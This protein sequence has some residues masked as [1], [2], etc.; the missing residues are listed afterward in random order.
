MSSNPTHHSEKANTFTA[1]NI[2]RSTGIQIGH[3]NTQET[4]HHYYGDK[5]AEK[6]IHNR[7][8]IGTNHS[9]SWSEAIHEFPLWPD[10]GLTNDFKEATIQLANACWEQHQRACQAMPN[11]VWVDSE[12]PIRLL[13]GLYQLTEKMD[14]LALNVAEVALLCI[15]P[16][17][18]EAILARAIEKMAVH[19]PLSLHDTGCSDGMR[20][21]LEKVHRSY[22]RLLRKA[23]RLH[24]SGN[25]EAAN[26]VALWLMHR[27]LLREPSIWFSSND[28]EY[29]LFD[30][31]V[32]DALHAIKQAKPLIK[33]T[34][35]LERLAKLARYCYAA[36]ERPSSLSA[37]DFVKIGWDTKPIHE[38][39]LGYLLIIAGAMA[40]DPRVL[41]SVLVEHIGVLHTP[42]L[43]K[44]ID[45][46]I[47][48]QWDPEQPSGFRLRA[49]CTH[50]APDY[51]LGEHV[52]NTN[53]ILTAAR[54][55][56]EWSDC[57][58]LQQLPARFTADGVE[59]QKVNNDA[60]YR[61][62]H[63]RFRLA[64]DQV[65][66][67][68]MGEQLYGDPSLAIRELYQN[69]LDACRYAEARL[70]YLKREGKS[71]V[72]DDWPREIR[73]KQGVENGRPYIECDDNGIGMDIRTLTD[74][75]T[76][77]GRRFA[78]TPEFLDEQAEWLAHDVRLYP[79][80]QFGIGVLSYFML[81]DDFE[82]ET[83]RMDRDGRPG[84]ALR[85]LISGSGSLIRL[86]SGDRKQS[87]TRIR[88][89]LSRT[90]YQNKPISVVDTLEELLWVADFATV[91]SD[92]NRRLRWTA[93]RLGH[94]DNHEIC[95]MTCKT[96]NPD[97]WWR[98]RFG[99]RIF[100]DN[101]NEEDGNYLLAD[102]LLTKTNQDT[103][104]C[105]VN[106]RA[107]QKPRLTIDRSQTIAWDTD[108]LITA[109]HDEVQSLLNWSAK[110]FTMVTHIAMRYPAIADQF[111]KNLGIQNQKLP[112]DNYFWS[113]YHTQSS[114][115]LKGVYIS[116]SMGCIPSDDDFLMRI[117]EIKHNSPDSIPKILAH[118]YTSYP[119]VWIF[120]RLKKFA[121]EILA[122]EPIAKYLDIEDL[123]QYSL[124][125][126]DGYQSDDFYIYMFNL[127]D[128]PFDFIFQKAKAL[129]KKTSD[130]V[131]RLRDLGVSSGVPE[132]NWDAIESLSGAELIFISVDLNGQF[133]WIESEIDLSHILNAAIKLEQPPVEIS[134]K[135]K[136]LGFSLLGPEPNW[137]L[138][139]FV[140]E[141][142][143]RLMSVALDNYDYRRSGSREITAT[144]INYIAN[145]LEKDENYVDARLSD[146]GFI[147]VNRK[148]EYN[149][150][151]EPYF[152]SEAM[153]SLNQEDR[154][155]VSWDLQ[156]TR[157][158]LMRD[159]SF[160]HILE[161]SEKLDESPV[162]IV[163]R[164]LELG[165]TIEKDAVPHE[166]EIIVQICEDCSR[167]EATQMLLDVGWT[168]P[169]SED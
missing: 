81:A 164:L 40:I 34:L 49:T 64:Q 96:S 45:E 16:L 94:D 115:Y 86:S 13:Q 66:E 139:G 76:Q 52:E 56:T 84:E 125:P 156:G 118:A 22:P 33:E 38:R 100:N 47:T 142:D 23:A 57:T 92:G 159:V 110:C 135:L 11:D 15:A 90:E 106:L 123:R 58:P 36:P 70:T 79:N 153:D 2:D 17:L 54:R 149:S 129:S 71:N 141:I 78:D 24:E 39:R 63:L 112:I 147:L 41:S 157:S 18:R 9:N 116:S 169:E 46:I 43:A 3:G 80:S 134:K 74:T 5:W 51:V 14:Q 113:T 155:L 44:L 131:S 158:L 138:V 152:T 83:C 60:A 114:P 28:K 87:G 167:E 53:T 168:P 48:A 107:E 93:G 73:F 150:Q 140:D 105:I 29:G 109:A 161:A 21:M 6:S 143:A 132:L 111:W 154:I 136:H 4:H 42:P 122:L 35:G 128:I 82:V 68:L 72:L 27:T 32:L 130:I 162:T 117:N 99:S 8:E 144:D 126:S 97:F 146:F 104:F 101:Y 165:F 75:F 148:K 69:A 19:E 26:Q 145:T 160:R 95:A 163:K 88:L 127:V 30:G 119:R 1:G 55:A 166:L 102:G 61:T 65:L 67:L 59:P 25:S 91:V 12:L 85:A 20:A 120:Q 89:Y 98:A 124:T 62:P 151:K 31:N 108:W 7:A 103:P 137:E 133:P 121:Q 77:A 50:P 37:R 10:D